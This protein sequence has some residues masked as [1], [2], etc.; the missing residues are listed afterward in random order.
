MEYFSY[1]HFYV[2]IVRIEKKYIIDFCIFILPKIDVAHQFFLIQI[3]LFCLFI[4]VLFF[5]SLLEAL[6]FSGYT[7]LVDLVVPMAPW[8][9]HHCSICLSHLSSPG[10]QP[11]CSDPHLHRNPPWSSLLLCFSL[12]KT[13]APIPSLICRSRV[14]VLHGRA[15]WTLRIPADLFHRMIRSTLTE[16]LF[17]S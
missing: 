14:E 11:G 17:S 13:R 5:A 3:G 12:S 8:C 15:G 6:G 4:W 7:I 10:W 16:I 2:F 1:F 9:P